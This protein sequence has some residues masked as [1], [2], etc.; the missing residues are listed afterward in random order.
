MGYEILREEVL[1]TRHRSPLPALAGAFLTALLPWLAACEGPSMARSIEIEL[2]PPLQLTASDGSGLE[3][4]SLEARGVLVSPLAFTELHLT[5]DN[6]E[7]REM[8]GR[9][10][11]LLP[12]GAAVSRFAMEIEG[13]WREGEVVERQR[14]REVYED[15]LYRR[16]DPAL[17]EQQAGNEFSAR[18]F[19]IPA[20]GTKRLIV[21]WS[22]ELTSPEEVYRIPLA[23]LP[24]IGELDVRVLVGRTGVAVA[25]ASDPEIR[26]VD[27]R[28]MELSKKRWRPDR[29]FE[30]AQPAEGAEG[31]RHDDL[32]L[33]RVRPPVDDRPQKIG[34]LAV[35]VDSSASRALGFEAQLNALG[36]LLDTLAEQVGKDLPVLVAAFDQEVEPIFEG[37]VDDFGQQHLD[38]LRRRGALGASHLEGALSWLHG[39]LGQGDQVGYQRVLLLTDGVATAGD[40][41]GA[42]LDE[43]VER[44]GNRGVVRLDVLAFGGL[45]D[46]ST[47]GALV[48]GLPQA[49]IVLDV[50]TSRAEVVRRLGRAASR[51][52][53]VT[54]E[55]AS[56][57]WPE[58]LDG[59]Q[60]GDSVLL[61]AQ[62]P[63]HR[64][65]QVRVGGRLVELGAVH[66]VERPLL[67]RAA[68]KARIDRLM[69]LRGR[70]KDRD[71]RNALSREVVAL[72][73]EHRVLSPLTA[74]LVLETEQDYDRYEI[75]RTALA[76][77]LTIGWEGL[78]VVDRAF[79]VSS[80]PPE[81]TVDAGVFRGKVVVAGEW[82]VIPGAVVTLE[83]QGGEWT[84]LTNDQGWFRFDD[85]PAGD[86]TLSAQLEGFRTEV[87]QDVRAS[88]FPLRIG[89]R[90]M[91]FE[92]TIMVD[93]G[94]D[95]ELD[96]EVGSP[97]QL[98]DVDRFLEDEAAAPEPPT[99]P[100][101][102]SPPLARPVPPA[103]AADTFEIVTAESAMAESEEV[104][105]EEVRLAEPEDEPEIEPANPWNG[106]FD[107][108]MTLLAEGKVQEALKQAESWHAE[109]PG[110]VSALIALGEACEAAGQGERA[111]RIYGS[112]IDLFPARAD[113]RRYAGQRLERLA[114]T[115]S[116]PG[117]LELAIDTYRH[118]LDQRSDH[119]SGYRLLAYALVKNEQ[120]SEAFDRLAAALAGGGEGLPVVWDRYPGVKQLLREDLGLVA[121]AWRAAEPSSAQQVEDQLIAAGGQLATQPS[122]RFVLNWETAANDVDLH[123]QDALGAHADYS[124][125]QLA[126]GGK[127]L[128]DVTEGFGP[129][130]FV[131]P[132]AKAKKKAR[133]YRIRAHYYSRGPMGWGLGKLQVI[134]HDG[135]GG[136]RF[137]EWPFVV[138]EDGAF[139]ELGVVE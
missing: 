29:D 62:L 41:S 39:Q 138:M 38:A 66:A 16:Q 27:Y 8:E 133:P 21:S 129:E 103:P 35:L 80:K 132:V 78:E 135:L 50:G 85:V 25:G 7:D 83:G 70:A 77:I 19:P 91:L 119:P 30:V 110:D 121:A 6:P 122:L 81:A 18:V 17:L 109:A 36:E 42:T 61:Y 105:L 93:N 32:M 47:L 108:I 79:D 34:S 12:P 89:L 75:D 58:Q 118:A 137:E 124:Q 2:P 114:S 22:H 63:K 131:I 23:G 69:A 101:A 13:E 104:T 33:L 55:G 3:L 60:E 113:L 11:I 53:E 92:E 84:V 115:G 116:T 45:R 123:V 127:L 73:V 117:A 40:T 31:L 107:E 28:V 82:E 56:W 94:A 99:L 134:E 126:S 68:V 100:A 130:A 14:A 87:L 48:G 76:D 20:R 120:Y 136:L 128:A 106:P 52:L 96:S 67:E 72:S 102:A 37:R 51:G 1:M 59:V 125:P 15:F 71:A 4:V 49:G 5:F 10:R 111:A 95:F 90:P 43:A 98:S 24:E 139:V 44:L 9:F 112:L 54:V 26:G 46:E 57:H 86:F 65:P 97:V 74:L 64:T 88:A